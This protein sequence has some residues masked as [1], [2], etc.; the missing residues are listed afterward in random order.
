[1]EFDHPYIAGSSLDGHLVSIPVGIL[2]KTYHDGGLDLG[3]PRTLP[4]NTETTAP[5][6]VMATGSAILEAA[7]PTNMS[8]DWVS[9]ISSKIR[10]PFNSEA[11]VDA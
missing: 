3:L 6:P 7:I 11:V 8:R 5:I 2:R 9:V 1:M 4:V 10:I